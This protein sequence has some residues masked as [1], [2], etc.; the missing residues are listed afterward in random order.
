VFA[1]QDNLARRIVVIVDHYEEADAFAKGGPGLPALAD[2]GKGKSLHFVLAGSAQVMRSG[3]D[4]L[5]KRA[6]SSRYSLLLQDVEAVRYLGARGNFNLTKELPPG[7]G[8]LVK[9]VSAA[10]VQLAMPG[11]EGPDGQ[12][13]QAK[14]DAMIASV[15]ARYPIAARWSYSGQDLTALDEALSGEGGAAAAPAA[16]DVSL[17]DLPGG[18]EIGGLLAS[19]DSLTSQ[20]AAMEIP[21]GGEFAEVVINAPD[22][23]AGNGADGS[24]G[25]DGADGADEAGENGDGAQG[26]AKSKSK[27]KKK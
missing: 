11:A 15:R 14:L 9:G 12:D 25:A 16:P 10:L 7:R 18:G 3:S 26:R 27:A 23:E 17:A 4:A 21:E 22:G 19:L 1:A 2:L 6:E 20:F 8:F 24:N 13:P 5:R